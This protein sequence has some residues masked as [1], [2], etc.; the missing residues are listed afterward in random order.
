MSDSKLV[1]VDAVVVELLLLLNQLAVDVKIDGGVVNDDDS[2][3]TLETIDSIIEL[4][5]N[6]QR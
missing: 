6:S 4:L 2:D 3:E 1:L 5:I